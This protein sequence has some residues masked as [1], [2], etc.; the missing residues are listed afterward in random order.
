[1][2]S[3]STESI[4]AD[5]LAAEEKE[6]ARVPMTEE[7]FTPF[8]QRTVRQLSAYVRR[9]SGNP[10]LAED[11]VQESY[12]R[13]LSARAPWDQGEDACRRYLFRIATNLLR[14]HWRRPVGRPLGEVPERALPAV[15]PP[16]VENPDYGNL[17]AALL[18][19]RPVER[20]LLWLAHAEGMSHREIAA[21]TGFGTARIRLALYRSRH[22]LARALRREMMIREVRR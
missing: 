5:P 22:K 9:V 18:S 11:L 14:D 10:S 4:L 8:Y 15:D 6:A 7:G 1:M 21:V 20:Q 3:R 16:P 17:G 2:N 12:L 13:L 19:L